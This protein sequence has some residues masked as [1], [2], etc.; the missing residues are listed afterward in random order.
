L[1]TWFIDIQNIWQFSNL[2]LDGIGENMPPKNNT[3]NNT[4]KAVSVRR[5]GEA[6]LWG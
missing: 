4:K 2:E 3:K 6:R 5:Q 1:V